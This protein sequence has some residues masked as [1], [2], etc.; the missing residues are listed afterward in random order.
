MRLARPR[1]EAL[2]ENPSLNFEELPE[3]DSKQWNF[4]LIRIGQPG[5]A[6]NGINGGGPL[7]SGSPKDAFKP[8][9]SPPRMPRRSAMPLAGFG[10]LSFGASRKASKTS[11]QEAQTPAGM[12]EA[13]P[14]PSIPDGGPSDSPPSDQYHGAPAEDPTASRGNSQ[15]SLP[16]APRIEIR[17]RN[18]IPFLGLLAKHKVPPYTQ[19]VGA[20]NQAKGP[21]LQELQEVDAPAFKATR[22][23]LRPS[24]DAGRATTD[25]AEGGATAGSSSLGYSPSEEPPRQSR[26]SFPGAKGGTTWQLPQMPTWL[27]WSDNWAQFQS[28]L[29]VMLSPP[30][31][32][33]KRRLMTV[34]EFFKYTADEGRRVL[35]RVLVLRA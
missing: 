14:K 17:L 10:A 16:S 21:D 23:S 11:P 13:D 31:H 19:H 3:T 33:D 6:R 24:E 12:L 20:G 9:K 32:P 4:G 8:S 2:Y 27:G 35:P 25:A 30:G 1:K 5:T 22:D 28:Q 29:R 26:S 34:Q 7:N 15:P 18:N